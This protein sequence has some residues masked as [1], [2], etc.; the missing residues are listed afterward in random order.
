[1]TA[2]RI[3]LQTSISATILIA[4]AITLAT[5]VRSASTE[6]SVLHLTRAQQ[7]EIYFDLN[8][9]GRSEVAPPGFMASVGEIVPSKINLV[10]V[11]ASTTDLVSIVRDYDYVIFYQFAMATNEVLLVEPAS[12]KIVAVIVP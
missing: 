7:R 8:I 1:M 3:P 4:A 6:E 9:R 11:P 12:R 10:S 5:A 2:R